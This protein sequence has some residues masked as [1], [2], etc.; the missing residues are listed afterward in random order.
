VSGSAPRN[1]PMRISLLDDVVARI[2]REQLV[3][4][5]AGE[6]DSHMFAGHRRHEIGRD[7]RGIRERLVEPFG[8]ARDD[9]DRFARG[10]VELGVVGAEMGRDRLGVLGLVV[11]GLAKAMGIGRSSV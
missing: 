6:R 4:A 5:V 10:D 3:A 9:V 2:A 1:G 11:A 8:Q 7:L